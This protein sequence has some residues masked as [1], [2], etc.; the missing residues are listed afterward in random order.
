MSEGESPGTRPTDGKIKAP[1]VIGR[2]W[3]VG[4]DL[5]THPRSVPAG[6]L[7]VKANDF[8]DPSAVAAIFRGACCH[9][10]ARRRPACPAR[11]HPPR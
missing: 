9:D 4:L 6:A 8:N 1:T 10:A 5:S 11:P 2:M 3:L 7:A